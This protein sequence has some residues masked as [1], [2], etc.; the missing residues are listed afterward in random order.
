MQ[1]RKFRIIAMNMNKAEWLKKPDHFKEHMLHT[2]SYTNTE[3]TS[4]FF[5]IGESGTLKLN[6]SKDDEVSVAFVFFHTPSDTIVFKGNRIE[7]SFFSLRSI[8]NMSNSINELEINK[9]GEE[10]IF[11]SSGSEILRISNPAFLSSASFGFIVEE[12]GG[13]RLTVW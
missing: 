1:E 6:Y 11:S 12:V 13:V 7:S 10:I 3:R 4:V 5:T 9:N 2:V 8:H